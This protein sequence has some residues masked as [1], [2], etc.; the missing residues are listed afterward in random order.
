MKKKKK[1]SLCTKITIV[2]LVVTFISVAL[3]TLLYKVNN[4]V[5][6]IASN[7][8]I[9]EYNY[10]MEPKKDNLS[11][12]F[13]GV[14]KDGLRTDS[15]IYAKY[16]TVNNKLYMM[17]I[18]RDTYTDNP[19]ATYKINSIYYGGKYTKEFVKEIEQLLDVSIDYYAIIDLDTIPAVI[20]EIDGLT[21]TLDEE[22][23]KLNKDTGEWYFVF[24]EGEQTLNAEQV[25]TLV[26]NRDYA[27][28]DISR[29]KM[30]RKILTALIQNMMSAKNILKLPTIANVILENTNTNVTVREAMKYISELKEINLEDITSVNMPIADIAYKVNGT[31]CVLVN[32]QEARRIISED[33]IYTI[34]EENTTYTTQTSNE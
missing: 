20:E 4:M 7:G 16:D 27:D 18:P 31:S 19:L 33:W 23:W 24:P 21:I 34:P 1:K 25:E 17:S 26:R 32:E 29:G 9:Q 6:I 11:V 22:I 8:S 30:Q 12:L 5:G 3:W 15:I 14:D 10:S 13:A 2:S 28:G